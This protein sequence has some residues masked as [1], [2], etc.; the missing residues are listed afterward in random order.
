M[1]PCQRTC[2]GRARNIFF[3]YCFSGKPLPRRFR[4]IGWQGLYLLMVCIL[5]RDF[6]RQTRDDP[7]FPNRPYSTSYSRSRSKRHHKKNRPTARIQSYQTFAPT[8]LYGRGN[9]PVKRTRKNASLLLSFPGTHMLFVIGQ[10]SRENAH[11]GRR[12]FPNTI[13][14]AGAFFS[15]AGPFVSPIFRWARCH[16]SVRRFYLSIREIL[17][18]NG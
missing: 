9:D 11:T 6:L 13:L 14:Y 10:E 2:K 7:D 17:K 18:A 5:K 4:R 3:V 15:Q 1:F 12:M 16:N 8:T